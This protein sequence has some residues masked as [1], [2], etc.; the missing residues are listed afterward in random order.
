[1]KFYI[2]REFQIYGNFNF[3]LTNYLP[4]IYYSGENEKY[5]CLMFYPNHGEAFNQTIKYE[6]IKEKFGVDASIIP[7]GACFDLIDNKIIEFKKLQ[8]LFN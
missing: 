3:K 6:D 5:P 1:M 7:H 4:K 8:L 2:I